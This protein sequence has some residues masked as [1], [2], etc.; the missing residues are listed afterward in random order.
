[1]KHL[2]QRCLVIGLSIA[3]GA[4]G[5]GT[6]SASA[7][8]PSPA[9][10]PAPAPAPVPLPTPQPT[11]LPTVAIR[12]NGG[13]LRAT[14]PLAPPLLR[15]LHADAIA[16]DPLRDQLLIVPTASAGAVELIGV[17][18]PTLATA[19]SM[20]LPA[21][22]T[23]MAISADASMVYIGLADG[24]VQQIDLATRLL[25]RQFA[26]SEGRG[27]TYFATS[28]AVRP[29]TNHTVAIGTGFIN[30]AGL[31]DF[32]RLAVWQDGTQWPQTLEEGPALNNGAIQV[33]FAD[34]ATLMAL[35]TRYLEPILTRILVQGKLLAPQFP[36]IGLCCESKAMQMYKDQVLLDGGNVVT[37]A[38]LRVKVEPAG[39]GGSF[40]YLADQGTLGEVSLQKSETEPFAS[41][42]VFSEY[43][44]DRLTLR[45]RAVFTVPALAPD[46]HYFPKLTRAIDAGKGR[47]VL[48]VEDIAFGA[49]SKLVL[50]DGG[51]LPLVTAPTS[52]SQAAT[53]QD[54]SVLSVT[55][56]LIGMAYDRARDRVLG[57]T[58]PEGGPIGN[59]LL[60]LRPTDGSI[61]ARYPLTSRPGSVRVS[62]SGSVAYVTLPEEN[63]F[64]RVDVGSAGTLRWRMTGLQ[65]PVTGLAISPA[66]TDT[67][68][69]ILA[70]QV[71]FTVYRGGT[72]VSKSPEAHMS[73]ITFNGAHEIVV[74]DQATTVNML[75]R[76]AFDGPTAVL[77]GSTPKPL[78]KAFGHAEF[79]GDIMQDS[80]SYASVAS[81]QRIGWILRPEGRVLEFPNLPMKT[82]KAAALWDPGQGVGVNHPYEVPLEVDY[83]S[84]QPGAQGGTLDM[85]GSRRLQ[86]TDTRWPQPPL[87]GNDV[88][89][90]IPIGPHAAVL[91]R[92]VGGA[93]NTTLYFIKGL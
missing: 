12:F 9:P 73:D 64:Q 75:S 13:D 68:A 66:D 27:T 37:P 77:L 90:V 88:R 39:T 56:P 5:G 19:W 29:G 47:I 22:A 70:H 78:W 14:L 32:H 17:A 71:G 79:S 8:V 25:V 52:V 53:A 93:N 65:R 7:P 54:V 60:V 91:L 55:L 49:P 62:A 10:S 43:A 69:V 72:S 81:G 26:L 92:S 74:L 21:A 4:C 45:R 24:T 51:S 16:Y 20:K 34:G 57:I 87:T 2:L 61:E 63:G 15:D 46:N 36:G 58:G 40:A 83:L 35:D 84:A 59:S 28:I 30:T 50:V 85:I 82:Y 18:A 42:I 48:Q 3:L 1:M 89:T 11:A 86:I 23:A 67:V 44:S 6:G 41:Q 33:L 38:T 31:L 76:Y 80:Y